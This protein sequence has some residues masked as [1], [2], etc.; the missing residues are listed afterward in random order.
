MV[1]MVG[2]TES[3]WDF[4]SFEIFGSS[5]SNSVDLPS[6]E[7]LLSLGLVRI[8]PSVYHV[9]LMFWVREHWA[10]CLVAGVPIGP[11]LIMRWAFRVL[12]DVVLQ[13]IAILCRVFPFGVE[14]ASGLHY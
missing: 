10:A 7:L 2:P 6:S 12:L 1:R 14:G 9:E 3:D 5:R 13:G 4:R 8:R 11:V